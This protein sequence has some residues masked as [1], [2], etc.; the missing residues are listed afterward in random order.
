[1]GAYEYVAPPDT[2]PPTPNTIASIVAISANQIDITS[3]EAQD[4][5]SPVY[6]QIDGQYYDGSTWTD[7]G[8]GVSDYDYSTTKPNP[9]PDTNLAANGWY[10]Y[11]QQ[12]KDSAT[13]PNES[14]WS[15]WF[16]KYTLAKTPSAP[17]VSNPTLTTLDVTI[18][19]NGNPSHTLFALYNI[20]GGYYVNASGGSNGGTEVW[21]T[22]S[23]WG[24]VTVVNLTPATTYEFK[25]KAQNGEGIETS[26]GT[27][28]SGTTAA[29]TCP[30]KILPES[31]TIQVGDTTTIN[32]QIEGVTN[33]GGFEFK[34]RYK[35]SIIEITASDIQ[36]GVFLT[37]TG[38]QVINATPKFSREGENTVLFYGAAT[39]GVQTPAS[40]TGILATIALKGIGAGTTTLDLFDIQ[41]GDANANPISV[42]VIDSSITVAPILYGD[43][44]GDGNITAYDASLVLRYVVG[45]IELSPE[46]Q[47]A[48][49]VTNNG[50]IS[51][52]DAA[53]IL[54]YTVGLITKFPAD[55][56]PVAPA[57]NSPNETQVLA[58]TIA[59]L[60]NISLTREQKQV[61]EQLKNLV[62]SQ[63]IPKHTALLQ[64]YP[65]PFNP[66]TWIPYELA[67]EAE[68]FIRIYN[69]KGQLVRT[70]HLGIKSAGSYLTKNRAAH[71]NG[72][73]QTGESASSGLYFY[74][75]Q[76]RP[77]SNG[78]GADNFIATKRMILL[79]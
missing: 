40:G 52:L 21:Q 36:V 72:R 33:L 50:T 24:T 68:V 27:S 65:N 31:Q 16:E 64:N 55:S 29:A 75:I 71:W 41:V 10:R 15:A 35:T 30:I 43:V 19:P 37:H 48:A 66:E 2:T 62:F 17:T 18:N 56:A 59:Q 7:S 60:E 3:T 1:M 49:D 34:L 69:T 9:W 42:D 74:T 57:L 8:G 38:K 76:A 70:L 20:T 63:L 25:G 78:I 6:Y 73:T 14:P 77:V 23:D 47:K 22:K 28:G 46:Q 53:L 45:S 54:Q 11:R 5:T 44:S 12:V 4:D 79:K 58:G 32:L 26:F 39:Y 13:P 51:A 61:L 67:N